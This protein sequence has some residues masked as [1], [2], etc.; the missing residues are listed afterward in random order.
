M[1]IKDWMKQ[2]IDE[3]S[4]PKTCFKLETDPS[5]QD[6]L[7]D[8]I[9]IFKDGAEVGT[10]LGADQLSKEICI[11]NTDDGD[12]FEFRNGGLNN[13]SKGLLF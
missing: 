5:V 13:V 12:A 4:P 8:E 7:G 11:E 3:Y 6:S 1:E 10:A 2:I 9:K